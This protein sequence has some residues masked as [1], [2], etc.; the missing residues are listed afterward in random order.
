M[1][2]ASIPAENLHRAG[3]ID[4][5]LRPHRDGG[6]R[7]DGREVICSIPFTHELCSTFR[8]HLTTP[9]EGDDMAPWRVRRRPRVR[10]YKQFIRDGMYRPMTLLRLKGGERKCAP[11]GLSSGRLN[12]NLNIIISM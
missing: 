12:L 2:L 6:G 1:G 4:G 3:M 7:P 8:S 9:E 5:R 10:L 11:A